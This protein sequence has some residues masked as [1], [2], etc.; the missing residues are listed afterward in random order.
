MF[1]LSQAALVDIF[2]GLKNP[3]LIFEEQLQ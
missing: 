1:S 2:E 3:V